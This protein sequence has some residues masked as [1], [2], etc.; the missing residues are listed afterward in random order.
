MVGD[1]FVWR[2]VRNQNPILFE[3]ITQHYAYVKGK[4]LTNKPVKIV[5]KH[6]LYVNL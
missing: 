1:F 2:M 6:L 3:D 5:S 4:L